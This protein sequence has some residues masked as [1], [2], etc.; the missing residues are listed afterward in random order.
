MHKISRDKN[1]TELVQKYL[2]ITQ[3]DFHKACEISHRV[4]NSFS[5][6]LVSQGLQNFAQDAKFIFHSLALCPVACTRFGISHAMRKF[7][8]V[9]Q[10]CWMLD[11]FSDSLPC[12]L[13]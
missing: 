12:I 4:R 3:E 7:R 9:I 10:N 2:K 1:L 8:I 6:A 11:F 5:S 13:D